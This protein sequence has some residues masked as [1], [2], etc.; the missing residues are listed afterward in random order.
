M[1]IMTV[2][3]YDSNHPSV[4]IFCRLYAYVNHLHAVFILFMHHISNL[5][6][7][8][9]QFWLGEAFTDHVKDLT[10]KRW[11]VEFVDWEVCAH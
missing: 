4:Q 2:L 9:A 7:K 11:T 6:Y 3:L 5:K 1:D 10:R 8:A